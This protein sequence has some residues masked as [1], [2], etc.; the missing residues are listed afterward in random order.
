MNEEQIISKAMSIL[1]SRT[2]D[3]K[4]ESSRRNAQRPRKHSKRIAKRVPIAAKP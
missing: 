3:R 2:S 4:R 1:G